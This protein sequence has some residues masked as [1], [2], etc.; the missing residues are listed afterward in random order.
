MPP[1]P[2][3]PQHQQ[4]QSYPEGSVEA[5]QDTLRPSEIVL[6]MQGEAADRGPPYSLQLHLPDH[7]VRWGMKNSRAAHSQTDTHA[8]TSEQTFVPC[9]QA[10]VRPC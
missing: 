10:R 7:I 1:P 3:P 2:P 4:P 8:Y 9:P 5:L 6:E